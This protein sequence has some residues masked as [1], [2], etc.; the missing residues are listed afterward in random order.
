QGGPYGALYVF[1]LE[2]LLSIEVPTDK[3]F[4][5]NFY[6]YESSMSSDKKRTQ[7][8]GEALFRCKWIWDN[9]Y[10]GGCEIIGYPVIRDDDNVFGRI[11]CRRSGSKPNPSTKRIDKLW[12][13]ENPAELDPK[14]KKIRLQDGIVCNPVLDKGNRLYLGSAKGKVSMLDEDDV[15]S[16]IADVGRKIT[17]LIIGPNESLVVLTSNGYVHLID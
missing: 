8:I 6:M 14:S 15:E 12:E 1:T 17:S 13:S 7:W 2:D 5:K 4:L 16:I 11:T 3:L 10:R 9:V